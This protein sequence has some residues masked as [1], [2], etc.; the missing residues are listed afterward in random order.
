MSKQNELLLG[1]NAPAR[2]YVPEGLQKRFAE[3]RNK[4]ANKAS[5]S[6]EAKSEK[7]GK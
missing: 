5:S 4:K 3:V 1:G 2:F 7:K 6:V